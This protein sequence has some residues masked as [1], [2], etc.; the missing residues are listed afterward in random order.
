MAAPAVCRVRWTVAPF[1]PCW[2]RGRRWAWTRAGRRP[3]SHIR[4]R[5][6]VLDDYLIVRTDRSRH[7][8]PPANIRARPLWYG[9]VRL[10]WTKWP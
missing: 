7:A 1:W 9:R 8:P 4:S 10:A 3:V 2:R 5:R 6:C